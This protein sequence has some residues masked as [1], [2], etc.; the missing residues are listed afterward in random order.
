MTATPSPFAADPGDDPRL[1]QKRAELEKRKRE[2]LRRLSEIQEETVREVRE[3]AEEETKIQAEEVVDAIIDQ[4]KEEE[5]DGRLFGRYADFP[6]MW[7]E[8]PDAE[9]EEGSDEGIEDEEDYPF[10]QM[11]ELFRTNRH[12]TPAEA[13]EKP[14]KKQKKKKR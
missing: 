5:S 1:A 4:D 2:I 10:S 3:E 14:D 7:D 8:E 12:D 13:Y 11:L 6:D 9:S